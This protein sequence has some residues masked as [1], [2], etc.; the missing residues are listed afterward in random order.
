[1]LILSDFYL[2]SHILVFINQVERLLDRV[3]SSTLLED[4]RDGCRALKALSRKY[5]LL[6]GAHGMDTL[7]QVSLFSSL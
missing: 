5:R 3:Q 6:V 1:M 2:Y 7:I 4:R